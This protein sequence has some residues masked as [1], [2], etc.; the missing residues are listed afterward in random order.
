MVLVDELAVLAT[1]SLAQLRERWQQLYRA[2]PPPYTPD[3]LRRGLAYRLQEKAFGSL[4]TAAR[5]ELGRVARQLAESDAQPMLDVK[6][7]PG[8]RLKRE[9]QGRVLS[10]LV[11]E[12]GFVLDDRHYTS[13]TS[14]AREVSGTNWS[15]PLFFGLKRRR[16]PP[17][18]G[19]AD[20]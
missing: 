1:L 11:V 9:W 20:A 5:R 16:K 4:P 13:L 8:T 18:K 19:P 14:I 12:D 3:L 2:A 6:L 7:K 10:V 17:R 15:G